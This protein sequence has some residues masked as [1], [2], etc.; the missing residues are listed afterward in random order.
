MG[1]IILICLSARLSQDIK[2]LH[3]T[4]ALSVIPVHDTDLSA[5]RS[6]SN[7]VTY[8]MEIP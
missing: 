5:T 3:L 1:P 4:S 8:F 6:I 2:I 7:N